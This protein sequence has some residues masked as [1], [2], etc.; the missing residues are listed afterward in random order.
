MRKQEEVEWLRIDIQYIENQGFQGSSMTQWLSHHDAFSVSLVLLSRFYSNQV[1][2]IRDDSLLFELFW[3]F[4]CSAG[5]IYFKPSLLSLTHHDLMTE[6]SWLIFCI[7]GSTQPILL[8]P[9][10]LDSGWLPLLIRDSH[11]LFGLFCLFCCWTDLLHTK[12]VVI[13]SSWLDD[14]VILTH[15]LYLWFYSADFAQTKFV[16]LRM[17][18][19]AN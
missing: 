5:P 11:V 4:C 7:S 19:S 1:C 3:L 6:S 18:P 8:Q 14:W 12:I 9:S 15:F 17:T 10:L 2:W 16:G 13:E